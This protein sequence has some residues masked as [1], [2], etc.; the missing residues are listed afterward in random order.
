MP[1]IWRM[2]PDELKENLTRLTV[3]LQRS[4]DHASQHRLINQVIPLLQPYYDEA[5][6]LWEHHWLG[7]VPAMVDSDARRK[8]FQD[9]DEALREDRVPAP[10]D[11]TSWCLRAFVAFA[12]LQAMHTHDMGYLDERVNGSIKQ[13]VMRE[14]YI[15]IAGG[16]PPTPVPQPIPQ[17]GINLV[18]T[19]LHM[20]DL[21]TGHDTEYEVV[22]YGHA[23]LS[24][25]IYILEYMTLGGPQTRIV[26][27]EELLEELASQQSSRR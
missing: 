7:I 22:D 23:T 26:S 2:T 8:W 13:H 24:G 15:Q 6:V 19:K 20:K 1:P 14:S 5:V 12:A 11:I 27:Q 10:D 3:I 16:P 18:G 17:T 25:D 21:N 4:M 9:V